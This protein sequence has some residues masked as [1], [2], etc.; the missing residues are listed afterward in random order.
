MNTRALAIMNARAIGTFVGGVAFTVFLVFL[1]ER[2]IGGPIFGG[3]GGSGSVA[4][5]CKDPPPPP[6]DT[7]PRCCFNT[8]LGGTVKFKVPRFNNNNPDIPAN[9]QGM[10]NPRVESPITPNPPNAP[11]NITIYG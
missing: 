10:P 9:L 5:A 8:Y 2:Y 4:E 6:P 7:A 11:C 3:G 1:V